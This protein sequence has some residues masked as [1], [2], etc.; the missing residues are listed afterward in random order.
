MKKNNSENIANKIFANVKLFINNKWFLLI[1]NPVV[2]GVAFM[3]QEY[4]RSSN[5]LFFCFSA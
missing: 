3:S 5:D 4:L 1:S 2:I